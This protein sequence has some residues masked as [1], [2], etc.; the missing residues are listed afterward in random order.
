MSLYLQANKLEMEKLHYYERPIALQTALLAN[1]HRNPKKQKPAKPEDYFI[2]QPRDLQNKPSGQYGAAALHLISERM[3][4]SWALFC[5]KDLVANASETVPSLV[6]FIG[7][8]ALLLAPA[9]VENGWKGMLIAS[10]AASESWV[11]MVSPC[12]KRVTLLVPRLGTK[13]VAQENS[14]LIDR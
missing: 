4:P 2:Y 12:G 14:I 9:K 8:D 13:Y 1:L 7:K 3:F 5:Y 11:D 6:A 10:E